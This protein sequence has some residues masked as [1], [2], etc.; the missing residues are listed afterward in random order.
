M[1]D[2]HFVEY[3]HHADI[4]IWEDFGQT[5]FEFNTTQSQVIFSH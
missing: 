3:V 2:S 1:K 5:G 4:A